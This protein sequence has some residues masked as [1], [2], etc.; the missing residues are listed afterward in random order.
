LRPDLP[1]T[2]R[3]AAPADADEVAEIWR[4]AAGSVFLGYR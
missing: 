4:A 2:I 1:V 3:K